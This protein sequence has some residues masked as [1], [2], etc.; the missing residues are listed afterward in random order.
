MTAEQ[1]VTAMTMLVE[2]VLDEHGPES[3]TLM[4]DSAGGGMALAVAQQLRDRGKQPHRIVLISPWL[5]V[6]LSDPR[7][8]E[9]EPHDV[10]LSVDGLRYCGGLYAGGLDLT[11]PRVSP[12]Y[13]DMTGLAPVDL[14]IGTHVVLDADV[15]QLEKV[16]ERDGAYLR[17]HEGPKL[18]HDFPILA[19]PESREARAAIVEL[20]RG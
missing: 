7:A 11:D 4:G 18:L 17:V 9:I 10:M 6:T 2:Q 8:R 19:L 1:T 15:P 12:I 14:F 16:M 13:G 20:V 3:V 5:D